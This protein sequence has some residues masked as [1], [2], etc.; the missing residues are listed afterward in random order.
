MKIIQLH[1]FNAIATCG[2]I[3][4]AAEVLH[5]SQ[6]AL[7]KSMQRLEQELGVELMA[8]TS[9]GIKLT[10]YGTTLLTHSKAVQAEVIYAVNE[11]KQ[12]QL[13]RESCIAFAVAPA[14][15]LSVLPK[16]IQKFSRQHPNI[17]LTISG[18]LAPDVLVDVRNGTMDFVIGVMQDE[19]PKDLEYQPF[20]S[21]NTIIIARKEH[22]LV[23]RSQLSLQDLQNQ[24]WVAAG[25][26]YSVDQP[27]LAANLVPP[28]V[29]V[30]C[31]SLMSNISIIAGSDAIGLVPSNYLQSA[32]FSNTREITVA[33][34]LPQR[35]IG[36]IKRKNSVLT[37]PIRALIDEFVSSKSI[38]EA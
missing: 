11:I 14:V 28:K 32:L 6:P 20:A 37:R 9:K 5:I 34:Q 16:I 35:E 29:N 12:M 31:E 33:E 10:D 8:R 19:V 7:T 13:Q 38:L 1:Q 4:K 30:V 24:F 36:I 18:K 17:E 26:T 27:F 15:S 3:R 23:N 21:I 25:G 22:P 2:S